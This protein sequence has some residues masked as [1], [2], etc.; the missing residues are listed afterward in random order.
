MIQEQ[1]DKTAWSSQ[2]TIAR[3]IA[4][5][6]NIIVFVGNGRPLGHSLVLGSYWQ[7]GCQLAACGPVNLWVDIQLS[8]IRIRIA[9]QKAVKQRGKLLNSEHSLVQ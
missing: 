7:Q 8:S 5:G 9:S 1:Q 6:D 3:M 2:E 4:D